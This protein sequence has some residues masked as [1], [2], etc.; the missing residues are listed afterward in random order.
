M[1]ALSD[2][3]DDGSLSALVRTPEGRTRAW[4]EVSYAGTY[5]FMPTRAR[6]SSLSSTIFLELEVGRHEARNALVP[7][8]NECCAEVC[9]WGSSLVALDAQIN[10]I[11][12][13]EF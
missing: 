6:I 1:R 5:F 3:D 2:D 11:E 9:W 4:V 8:V 7:T 10:A 13:I 12:E